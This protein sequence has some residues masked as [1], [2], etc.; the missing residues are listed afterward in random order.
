MLHFCQHHTNPTIHNYNKMHVNELEA[1]HMYINSV[2]TGQARIEGHLSVEFV[3]KYIKML[4][5]CDQ[6]T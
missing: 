6:H 2:T 5:F 3:Q 1:M 4:V